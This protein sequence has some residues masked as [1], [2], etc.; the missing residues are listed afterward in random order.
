MSK[1]REAMLREDPSLVWELSREVPGYLAVGKAWDALRVAVTSFDPDDVVA[2]FFAGSLG[3]SFG[4][5]G[6]FGKPRIVPNDELSRVARAMGKV[7]SRF[8][9]DNIDA[10]RGKSVHGDYFDDEEQLEGLEA[11]FVRVRD[12]VTGTAS[13]GEAMLVAFR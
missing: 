6:A 2:K 9:R 8:V 5:S 1:K 12:L 3:K 13:R 4:E 11:T 7:P 10:L